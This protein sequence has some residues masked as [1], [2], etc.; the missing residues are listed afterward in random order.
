MWVARDLGY[1][2]GRRTGLPLTDEAHLD[3][4]K[5]ICGRSD[6]LRAT[7]G[8]AVAERTASVVWNMLK[9]IDEPVVLWNVFPFH[10]HERGNPLSNRQHSRKE[11]EATL[12]LFEELRLIFRPERVFA[13][14]RNAQHAI[15]GAG[16]Q[17]VQVRHPSYGGQ[18][19]FTETV[20][21]A[22]SLD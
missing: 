18:T 4:A 19:E 3:N 8:D 17:A 13:I 12:P 21:A 22:Y 7:T 15:A 10:P 6:I 1:R 14:G 11:R 16:I 20:R 5:A 9:A 2:G